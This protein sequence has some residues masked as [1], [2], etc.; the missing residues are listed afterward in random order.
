MQLTAKRY[1]EEIMG[2]KYRAH[3]RVYV[4]GAVTHMRFGIECRKKPSD[5]YLMRK[6]REKLKTITVTVVP[7]EEFKVS[8]D[9]N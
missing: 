3:F 6:T 1:K 4:D 7:E 2:G 5:K 9:S 8:I